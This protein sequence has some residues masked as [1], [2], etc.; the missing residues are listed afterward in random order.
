MGKQVSSCKSLCAALPMPRMAAAVHDC[1]HDDVRIFY[2]KVNSKR[3]ARN[4]VTTRVSSYDRV[5]QW[6]I[7]DDLQGPQSFIQKF[8]P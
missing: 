8:M 7:G 5:D 2:T 4:Q 6:L 1:H 3:K